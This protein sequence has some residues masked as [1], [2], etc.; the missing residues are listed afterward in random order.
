[1][2]TFFSQGSAAIDMRGGDSF[3]SNFLRRSLMNLTVKKYENWPTFVEVIA[4][5]IWPGT[6]DTPCTYLCTRL[7]HKL[8]RTYIRMSVSKIM[9]KRLHR[10]TSNLR[11]NV[12]LACR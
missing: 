7:R 5:Q 9:Q 4:R 6:F 1:M 12:I 2:T 3:N 11:P 8:N 10:L